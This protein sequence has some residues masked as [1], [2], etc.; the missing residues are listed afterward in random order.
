M[1]S[2]EKDENGN[3]EK[4]K[5]NR[6]VLEDGIRFYYQTETSPSLEMEKTEDGYRFQKGYLP[7]EGSTLILRLLFPISLAVQGGQLWTLRKNN[8][9]NPVF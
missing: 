1:W 3:I 7:K 6:Q 9:E 2:W 4:L 8:Y 5:V